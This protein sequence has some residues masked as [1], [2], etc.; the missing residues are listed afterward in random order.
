[1][2]LLE[3][4]Q[5]VV[6]TPAPEAGRSVGGS[7]V[8]K[9]L[10]M[11]QG[12]QLEHISAPVGLSGADA[13]LQIEQAIAENPAQRRATH[14]VA[15]RRLPAG[16]GAGLELLDICAHVEAP[17]RI[18]QVFEIILARWDEQA[19]IGGHGSSL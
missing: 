18:G 12:L 16:I 13:R 9:T 11:Q 4:A 15:P 3:L 14:P 1:M 10:A 5:R 2:L 8:E 17:H 19:L 7:C 6:V